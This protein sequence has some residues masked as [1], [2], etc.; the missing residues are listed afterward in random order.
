MASKPQP[1]KRSNLTPKDD[2]RKQAVKKLKEQ[3]KTMTP[4]Q[5]RDAQTRASGSV[6]G[7]PTELRQSRRGTSWTA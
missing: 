5:F 1:R 2:I 4:R 7:V 6:I 3:S